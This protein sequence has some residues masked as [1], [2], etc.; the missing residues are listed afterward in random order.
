M[1]LT[2]C[3]KSFVSYKLPYKL[4]IDVFLTV[5][6]KLF[7]SFK[8]PYKLLISYKLSALY[9]NG[10]I[11]SKTTNALT[12]AVSDLNGSLN[13]NPYQN[14]S[15]ELFCINARKIYEDL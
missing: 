6:D 4:Y 8:L 11:L 14:P 7:V 2:V 3:D 5:C 15:R 1:F 9:G 12:P 13:S 10:E